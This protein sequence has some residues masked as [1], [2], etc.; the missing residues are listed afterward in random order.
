VRGR[1]TGGHG[2]LVE[3]AGHVEWSVVHLRAVRDT[4]HAWPVE[5]RVPCAGFH[6]HAAFRD[7]G[8]DRAGWRRQQ[9]LGMERG[10]RGRVTEAALRAW[11]VEHSQRRDTRSRPVV[12][13][14]AFADVL[15][16]IDGLVNDI[17][18]LVRAD[19][20]PDL[21]QPVRAHLDS[22][23]GEVERI[24]VALSAAA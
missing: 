12:E 24:A 10:P 23:T 21:W 14:P 7:G 5:T 18:T 1:K 22:L 17:D 6:V 2:R 19:A 11:R 20:R 15:E 3:L 8:P 9:L 4:A 16:R 13:I